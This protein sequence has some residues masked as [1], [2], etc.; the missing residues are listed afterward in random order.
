MPTIGEQSYIILLCKG[1]MADATPYWAYLKMSVLQA[2]GLKAAQASGQPFSLQDFGEIL[3]W[4]KEAEVPAEI[5]T[6]MERDHR[7]SHELPAF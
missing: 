4:G 2:K 7:V 3:A 5:R 6:A 1:Q